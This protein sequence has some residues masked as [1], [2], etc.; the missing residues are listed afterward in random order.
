MSARQ[1]VFALLLLSCGFAMGLVLTGGMRTTGE[2]ALAEP[3]PVEQGV[4]A[5]PSPAAPTQPAPA[6]AALAPAALPDFSRVAERSIPAVVNV[7]SRQIVRRQNSPFATDP[8]F[9]H[10][11]KCAQDPRLRP[12][13][14][15]M[16]QQLNGAMQVFRDSAGVDIRFE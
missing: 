16:I 7:S 4:V 11:R 14:E 12:S 9:S 15:E 1:F 2:R 3:V 10:A 13:R 5:A 8:F 6:P